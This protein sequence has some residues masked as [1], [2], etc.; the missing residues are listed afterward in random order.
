MKTINME[1]IDTIILPDLQEKKPR[2]KKE[3]KQVLVQK[4]IL[5]RINRTLT[6]NF[7]KSEKILNPDQF[8]LLFDIHETE[9]KVAE[10]FM[11]KQCEMQMKRNPYE[12]WTIHGNQFFELAKEIK[13]EFELFKQAA[14]TQPN[15]LT[16]QNKC[17]TILGNYRIANDNYEFI[18]SNQLPIAIKI[19]NVPFVGAVILNVYE[20]REKRVQIV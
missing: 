20:N 1:N 9:D 18:T 19:R 16:L 5:P 17:T 13:V 15:V 2:A 6:C 10:D 3:P 14:K 4:T 8:Q 11:C 12:F 7:C